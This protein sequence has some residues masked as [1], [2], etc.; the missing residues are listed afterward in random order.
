MSKNLDDAE[1][2]RL[3]AMNV[4]EQPL[5]ADGVQHVAGVDEVGRGA[6]AGPVVA[7]AV[8][9][10]VDA[11]IIGL[12]D[13]KRLTPKKREVLFDEITAIAIAYGLGSVDAAV[14]DTLNIRRANLQAMKEAVEALPLSPGH[15]LIDGL[16][17]I[18]WKGPQ[19][20]IVRGD[21]RSLTIAAASIIAKVTRDRIMISCDYDY[22]GYGFAQHKGYGTA[23]HL[24][25]I[26][27]KGLSN[28]H[29]RS[30]LQKRLDITTN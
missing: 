27:V 25:A 30:F 14:I 10:P 16:D 23:A 28:I 29:R 8:I 21:A 26:D 1:R 4:F 3:R 11:M 20:S 22:P 18:E 17:S 5:H 19:T 13:S 7:A 24:A 9:L 2:A 12:D 6:L 15:L